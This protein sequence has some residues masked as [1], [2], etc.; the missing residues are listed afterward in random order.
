MKYLVT[1]GAGFIGSH[2][3][4]HLVMQ[5]EDV[6]VLDNFST[7]KRENISDLPVSLIEGDIVDMECV[8]K[9][10]KGVDIVFHQAALSSVGRSME[11]PASTHLV[12]TTGTLNVLEA[13]R[14]EGVRRV[15]FAS[16]SSVYG[17]TETLPKHEKMVPSP[18]SPYAISKLIGEMYCKAYSEQFGLET[19]ALRYFNV[20]GPRQDVNSDYAAVIPKFA[21]ALLNGERPI[22]YGDGEQTRDFTYV[23]NVVQANIAASQAHFTAG[24]VINVA[25]GQRCGLNKL[26]LMIEGI[27]DIDVQPIFT[28]TRQG[29]VKHS[30]ASIDVAAKVLGYQPQVGLEEGLKSTI[31]WYVE[32]I[33]AQLSKNQSEM[34]IASGQR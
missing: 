23:G 4:R 22:I 5:G 31:D 12:N 8:R 19:V 14:Q 15:V 10:V 3:A 20:F 11:D 2:I 25:C 21:D 13:S 16:S 32:S 1:G 26:L 27:L 6:T 18:I 17:N 33:D 29:D 9:A 24:S 34:P 28:E 30:L 7:G